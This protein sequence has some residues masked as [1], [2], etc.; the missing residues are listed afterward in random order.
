M[1]KGG[2]IPAFL[3]TSWFRDVFMLTFL[4]LRRRDEGIK[5][6][7]ASQRGAQE[8][9]MP[10]LP[11]NNRGGTSNSTICQII[12]RRVRHLCE[13]TPRHPLDLTHVPM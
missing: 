7:K 12:L 6:L 13:H 1:H 10:K 4:C 9:L 2:L 3:V 11:L 5:P 8:W